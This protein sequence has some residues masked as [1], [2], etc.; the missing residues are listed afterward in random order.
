ML[1]FDLS[2]DNWHRYPTVFMKNS[3][4]VLQRTH[5]SSSKPKRPRRNDIVIPKACDAAAEVDYEVELAVIIGS[6]CKNV[7]KEGMRVWMEF[8]LCNLLV[9]TAHSHA[10]QMR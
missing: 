6:A 4:A 9:V 10:G 3:N 7:R 5:G 1:S 8:S 2:G